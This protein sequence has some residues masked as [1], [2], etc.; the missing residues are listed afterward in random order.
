M[1]NS[2]LLKPLHELACTLGL[3]FL[4]F[5]LQGDTGLGRIPV[6]S[7]FLVSNYKSFLL[8]C[9]ALIVSVLTEVSPVWG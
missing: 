4:H 7:L 9:F 8:P 6:F 2:P 5:S 1:L 3:K